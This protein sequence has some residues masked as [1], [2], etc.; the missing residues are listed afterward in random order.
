MSTPKKRR[1]A[2]FRVQTAGSS[3]HMASGNLL[4]ACENRRRVEE[5]YDV[6]YYG[7]ATKVELLIDM[8]SKKKGMISE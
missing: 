4:I 5:H 3:D 7:R 2:V 6:A 1:Y 8:E